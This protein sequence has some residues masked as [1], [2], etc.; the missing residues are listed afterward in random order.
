[1]ARIIAINNSV[2]DDDEMRIDDQ[3]VRDIRIAEGFKAAQMGLEPSTNSYPK[4][5]FDEL[6]W[7]TGFNKFWNPF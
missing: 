1:M 3:A 4:N 6:W 7:N 2:L 5:S